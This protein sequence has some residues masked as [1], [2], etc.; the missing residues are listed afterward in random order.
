[1]T[2]RLV[3]ARVAAKTEQKR[4]EEEEH[5]KR[6]KEVDGKQGR[7]HV[8]KQERKSKRGRER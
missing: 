2:S 8:R 5:L 6:R 3:P 1:M 7:E 4:D